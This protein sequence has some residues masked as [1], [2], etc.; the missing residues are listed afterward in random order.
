MID[1]FKSD[2]HLK[3]P[4][5]GRFHLGVDPGASG[6]LALVHNN[7][8]AMAAIRLSET[9]AD[10]WAWLEALTPKYRTTFAFI[11]R[12]S[13]MP[14]QGVASSFKFGESYGLCQMALTASRIPFE[15]V[16][17][18]QWQKALS[19]PVRGDKSK[20]EHKRGL[21]GKAQQLFPNI[22]VTNQLAD[23]LLI[24]EYCRRLNR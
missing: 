10:I 18:R 13:S 3:L 14:K 20:T 24:A 19:I 7:G 15:Y 21:K 5:T 16:T 9:M 8:E 17:P 2:G 11:E 12:V 22:K 4:A 6:A 1:L 23:A